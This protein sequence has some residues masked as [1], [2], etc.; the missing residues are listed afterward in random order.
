MVNK[1]QDRKFFNNVGPAFSTDQ[2]NVQKFQF[3]GNSD[4]KSKRRRIYVQNVH[5]L[6]ADFVRD[7]LEDLIVRQNARSWVHRSKQQQPEKTRR[8]KVKKKSNVRKARLD[9][10]RKRMACLDRSRR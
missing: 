9:P 6:C 5:V 3:L 7:C 1:I 10:Q 8:V 2:H 4:P